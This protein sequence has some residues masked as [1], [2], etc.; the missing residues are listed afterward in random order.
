[1]KSNFFLVAS[2]FH[3]SLFLHHIRKGLLHPKP[4]QTRRIMY[5]GRGRIFMRMSSKLQRRDMSK[6]VFYVSKRIF[7][8]YLRNSCSSVL[9]VT[10]LMLII[11]KILSYIDI[12]PALQSNDSMSNDALCAKFECGLTPLHPIVYQPILVLRTFFPFGFLCCCLSVCLFA[13]LSFVL[14]LFF[15]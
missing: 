13:C 9:L 4:V 11:I 15:F 2:H 1:M 8:I 7:N 6:Y 3:N 12:A 10:S 5:R 14:L